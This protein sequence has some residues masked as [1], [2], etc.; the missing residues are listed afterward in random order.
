MSGEGI[1]T[2]GVIDGM[3]EENSV[4]VKASSEMLM[5]EDD[6]EEDRIILMT[7]ELEGTTFGVCID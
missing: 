2:T 3:L 4:V 7:P 6:S 1:V 5:V